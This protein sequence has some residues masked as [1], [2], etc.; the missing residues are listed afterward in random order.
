MEDR[1]KNIEDDVL[2]ILKCLIRIEDKLFENE[3]ETFRQENK[4]KYKIQKEKNNG[5]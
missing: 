1:L 2:E 5:K 4:K 3:H